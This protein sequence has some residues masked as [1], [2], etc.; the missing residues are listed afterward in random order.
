MRDLPAS[1]GGHVLGRT[2]LRT[3]LIKHVG[4]EF[5]RAWRGLY[6]ATVGRTV[7]D[8]GSVCVACLA[9]IAG[10]RAAVAPRPAATASG[11]AVD[12]VHAIPGGVEVERDATHL[13]VVALREDVLR[14]RMWKGSAAPED[15]SWAVLPAARAA[16]AAVKSEPRGFATG[17]ARVTIAEDLRITVADLEGH[18]LQQD[19]APARWEGEGF[20]VQKERSVSDHVFGLGDK[21][22]PFDHAGQTFTM[23]N[24]DGFGLEGGAD[25][26]YKSIPFFLDVRAHGRTL[27]V[28][29]DNTWRTTFDFGHT[30]PTRLSIRAAGGPLDSYLLVGDEPKEVLSAWT[31]LTGPAP[32]PPLWALGFQQS[33][34]SYMSGKELRS[35]AAR[36]RSEHIPAD[37][38]WLDIDF[39]HDHWPFTVGD[40]YPD[41]GTMVSELKKDGFHLVVITDLHVARQPDKGYAPYDSGLLGDH[42]V[43]NADGTVYVGS[44]WPG[45]SVF[46]DFTRAETRRWWGGLY[47]RFVADGID[48]FW[49]D[50]NEPAVFDQP[51]KTMP[52]GTQHRIEEPGF[53]SRTTS[54]AEIHNVFGMQNARATFE[55]QLSLRPDERPFVMTRATYAGGHRYGAT[56]TGDNS[57]SWNH[58]RLSVAQIMNLGLSG[59]SLAGADVGGF[60]GSPSPDLLTKWIEIG[61]FQPIFRDHY[62]KGARAHEP[63]VDGPVHT[64]IRRRYIEERYR[65]MP[66]LYTVV[67]ESS[68]TGL[69]IDRPLFVEFPDATRDGEPLDLVA[70]G[71]DFLLG[72]RILVAPSPSPEEVGAYTVHLPPGAWYD[73]WTDAVSRPRAAEAR[74]DPELVKQGPGEGV[75]RVVPKLEILPVYV[76][77]G[78]ILPLSAVTQ[79][80]GEVPKGP[81]VLRVYPPAEDA[82]AG[83][84]EGEV[85][86][87]DGHSFAFRK[88]AYARV[89]F[90]CSVGKDGAVE[91]VIAP[92]E[93]VL[94][95]WWKEY[96]IEVVGL[97]TRPRAAEGDRV[98]E[99]TRE[100]G[101]WGARVAANPGGLRIVLR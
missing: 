45:P 65:L 21:T 71:T 43:K 39:Q 100:N 98:V 27:G 87:D 82:P 101:R 59:F 94:P 96:R 22:G 17:R 60:M 54:H 13:E 20:V 57:S 53:R 64:A 67:E 2:L 44:V 83:R 68:R 74:S 32:L 26:I 30:D 61:A 56:W 52:L 7:R 19:A 79:S 81:L 97:R 73:Y 6:R 40:T 49:N 1:T 76:R 14:V 90:T 25:P 58:L 29:L 41:F 38:L 77:A 28:F 51:G 55:G 15:A 24:T 47:A 4:F 69:P 5:V 99:V 88:G 63:W 72:G 12:G 9:M 48:G 93:G 91:V 66:Y 92:Q 31:W 23:W 34:Y 95:P 42:F 70:R 62:D 33:R 10:C 75:L 86:T 37:A 85:Y 18:I 50:M 3:A 89:R 11:T 8:L 36:L 35:T 84:C 46:P 78:S 80:T 16:R